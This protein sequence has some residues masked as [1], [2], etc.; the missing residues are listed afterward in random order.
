LVKIDNEL[1]RG[2]YYQQNIGLGRQPGWLSTKSCKT[3]CVLRL[4]SGCCP[5]TE[6]SGQ[7]YSLKLER[8]WIKTAERFQP[9]STAYIF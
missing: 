9:I 1:E 6:V 2:F 8:P 7:L 5:E 4:F 3:P